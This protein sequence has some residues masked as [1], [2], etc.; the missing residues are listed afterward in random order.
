[1]LSVVDNKYEG[2][3]RNIAKNIDLDLNSMKSEG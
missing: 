1:M 3:T 2:V